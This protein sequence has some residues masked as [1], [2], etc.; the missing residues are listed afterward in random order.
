MNH[1]LET[2]SG[3][4]ACVTE[5]MGYLRDT[6]LEAGRL[7]PGVFVFATRVQGRRLPAPK[8]VAVLSNGE[9]LEGFFD[10]AYHRALYELE[11]VGTA[12]FAESFSVEIL[13]PVEAEAWRG[14]DL[15]HHPRATRGITMQLEHTKFG[16]RL[17]RAKISPEGT[18]ERFMLQPGTFE[19][20]EGDFVAH[21]RNHPSTA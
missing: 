9:N 8:V 20:T 15:E 16:A 5:L 14:R 13:D 1:D 4:L 2:E 7:A 6:F 21:L 17:W 19:C 12:S 18:I 10:R 3:V 11:A